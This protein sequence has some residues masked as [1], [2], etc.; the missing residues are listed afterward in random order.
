[1]KQTVDFIRIF[2][3][4]WKSKLIIIGVTLVIT[5]LGILTTRGIEANQYSARV[6][7]YSVSTDSWTSN[8]GV[9]KLKDYSEI[10]KSKMVADQVVNTLTDAKLKSFEI[11]AMV[12]TTFVENSA[13]FYI[14]AVTDNPKTAAQIA[15]AVANAFVTDVGI[16]TG[17]NNVKILDAADTVSISYN[18]SLEKLKTRMIYLMVGFVSVCTVIIISEIF[19]IKVS[20]VNDSTLNGQ[21]KLL[22]VIPKHDI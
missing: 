6:S 9:N 13:I 15:N 2:R 21:I 22:G 20:E 4:L 19:S 3:R 16:I 18:A 10:V 17:Q 5:T 11:Q 8:S 7:L 1:M 14:T 12:K